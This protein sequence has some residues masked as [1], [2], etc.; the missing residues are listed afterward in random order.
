MATCPA[1]KYALLKKDVMFSTCWLLSVGPSP[2]FSVLLFKP[3]PATRLLSHL[4]LYWSNL[5]IESANKMLTLSVTGRNTHTLWEADKYTLVP[6]GAI[7]PGGSA[8]CHLHVCMC[9]SLCVFYPLQ[10]YVLWLI[11]VTHPHIPKTHSPRLP[12]YLALSVSLSIS[13]SFA[14]VST[15][16]CAWHFSHNPPVPGS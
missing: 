1:A 8:T 11:S 10:M 14:L 16:D 5:A 2:L 4:C 13:H 12:L 15:S 9:A 3:I 7:S 6:L